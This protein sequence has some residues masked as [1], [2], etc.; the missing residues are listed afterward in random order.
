MSRNVAAAVAR[1]YLIAERASTQIASRQADVT[2]FERLL[3]QAEDEFNAG[4]GTRLDVAQANV[5]LSRAK[6]ALLVA[7]NDRENAVLALLNA[8][9]E[10]ESDDVTLDVTIPTPPATRP[11][12]TDLLQRARA[13]RPELQQLATEEKAARLGVEAARAMRMP[14]LAFDYEGD[15]SGNQTN[16]LRY[17]RRIAGVV[18][19]PLLRSDIRATV[20]RATIELHDVETQIVQRQRDV[21][22]DV[23]RASMNVASAA[24]RVAVAQQNVT[25][26]EEALTIARDR[27]AAGYGSPVE[28]DRA[29]DSYRQAREDLIA[30]QADAAAAEVDLQ[31]ATGD[32][33]KL[34]ET[35][36]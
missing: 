14:S 1:L 33:A 16:D 6:Q 19:L 2:L 23:R 31:H 22:Q 30:A 26:A 12:L 13:N 5:Q 10:N 27:R 36:P 17:S 35:P 28:V 29:E 18:S 3:K 15:L 20:A 11:P 8:I 25:V 7:R 9:G 21:E 24:E 34:T 4:A 32:I